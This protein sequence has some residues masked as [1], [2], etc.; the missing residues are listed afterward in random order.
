MTSK[1][2]RTGN[3][4]TFVLS[5]DGAFSEIYELDP[6]GAE[7]PVIEDD[8]LATTGNVPKE[9]GDLDNWD[10]LELEIFCDPDNPPSRGTVQTGTITYPVP[11][12]GETGAT[13]AGTGFIAKVKLGA[14]VNN[15]VR[16]A[17]VTWNWDGKTGPTFTSST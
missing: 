10:P 6:G 3:A 9:P 7:L 5:T 15:Q 8:V 16:K 13:L 2:G 14:L 1:S 12:G 4:G 17:R 11:V